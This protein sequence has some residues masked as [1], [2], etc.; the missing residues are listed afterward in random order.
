[1]GPN[2]PADCL[3]CHSTDY[4]LASDT[5][6]PTG[7]NA[8]Y[9]VTCQACHTP[10][11]RGTAKGIWNEE[12]TPQ[13]RTDSPKTVCLTCHTAELNG[14][15]AKAG[16]AVH[17]TTKEVMDGTGAIDVPQG[18]P[19]VH[20]GKCVQCHMPPTI[21][22]GATGANHTF[23]IIQPEVAAAVR[24][25]PIV[26]TTPLPT[27]PYSACSTCHSRTGDQDATWLQ[28]T[29][30]DRQAAMHAWNDQVTKALTAAAKRL[31]FKSTAA[32]N[33]AINKK[34]M[35]KWSRGQMAFQKAFT[36]QTY[37]VSE[38]SWGIHNWDYARTVILKSL[39]Q[40]RSVKK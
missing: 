10:H 12:W 36:N 26:T 29:I 11:D 31:G 16:S 18:A 3:R 37:V 19:S 39:A 20:K 27:M 1:M 2:P 21:S 24:P 22:S 8:K 35:K 4:I 13:L 28:D 14:K 40:A 5:A 32:A 38:G 23:S 30:T 33:T 9:G 7:A 25:N 17:D 34:P 15:V 6:K